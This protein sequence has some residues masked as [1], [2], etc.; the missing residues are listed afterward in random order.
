MTTT[1]DIPKPT[2]YIASGHR[3]KVRAVDCDVYVLQSAL[4]PLGIKWADETHTRVLT[5]KA[6]DD[7]LGDAKITM[8]RGTRPDSFVLAM[9]DR[10]LC[11]TIFGHAPIRLS[12]EFVD[13][14]D[15]LI[16][17]WIDDNTTGKYIS[18]P[19]HEP[20]GHTWA[21]FQFEDLMENSLFKMRFE[22]SK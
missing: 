14:N 15:H 7:M 12:L 19:I 2:D 18:E 10:E 5:P 21:Y 13:N 22:G 4:E 8:L 1:Y 6:V 20:D 17:E 11:K 3:L 9:Q 16:A